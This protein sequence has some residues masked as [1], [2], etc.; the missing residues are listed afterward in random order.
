MIIATIELILAF[1]CVA[2]I[3]IRRARAA[4]EI[5][6]RLAV[7]LARAVRR[8]LALKEGAPAERRVAGM[9]PA[10]PP[11][12]RPLALLSAP[13]ASERSLALLPPPCAA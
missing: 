13:Q 8:E 5:E 6:E 3:Y 12:E 4:A 7:A 2:V 11:S 1:V 9:L 10:P